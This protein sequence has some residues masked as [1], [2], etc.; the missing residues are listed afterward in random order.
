MLLYV[1]LC[2]CLFDLFD[3]MNVFLRVPVIGEGTLKNKTLQFLLQ[4]QLTYICKKTLPAIAF[5]VFY[6]S[7][8]W[9]KW[10]T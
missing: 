10:L 1:N 5:F 6:L 4:I 8:K 7:L 2:S 9:Y 3:F